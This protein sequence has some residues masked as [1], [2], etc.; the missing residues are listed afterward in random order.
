MPSN[1]AVQ[2]AVPTVLVAVLMAI[3]IVVHW[4]RKHARE[5]AENSR[6]IMLGESGEQEELT[7]V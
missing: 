3:C 1:Q 5:N 2:I 7:S 6:N 4:C